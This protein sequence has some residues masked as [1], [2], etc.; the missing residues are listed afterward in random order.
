MRGSHRFHKRFQVYTNTQK[1]SQT[2]ASLFCAQNGGQ[3]ASVKTNSEFK[4]AAKAIEKANKGCGTCVDAA[5]TGGELGYNNNSA[6]YWIDG[7]LF[8]RDNVPIGLIQYFAVGSQG[9]CTATLSSGQWT[10]TDCGELYYPMCEFRL[11]SKVRY[12][13]PPLVAD[14]CFAGCLPSFIGDGQW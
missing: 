7:Q 2:Y 12:V 6:Y 14:A 1:L 13:P 11:K 4:A 10:K 5:W 8:Y 3:L 9:N